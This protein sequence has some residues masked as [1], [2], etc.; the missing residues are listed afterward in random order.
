MLHAVLWLAGCDSRRIPLEGSSQYD[1]LA[2]A[3]HSINLGDA[4]PME[5]IRHERLEP[6]VLDASNVLRSLEIIRSAIG[7]SFTGVVYNWPSPFVSI[8]E[9]AAVAA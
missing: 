5:D 3:Q 6:H 9:L 2:H 4:E 1:A 8:I 7:A